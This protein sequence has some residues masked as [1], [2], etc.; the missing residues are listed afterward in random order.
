MNAESKVL[1]VVCAV[2][3]SIV[4][5]LS[6]ALLARPAAVAAPDPTPH[7]AAVCRCACDYCQHC[8]YKTG[9]LP[10]G[11]VIKD[12]LLDAKP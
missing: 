5:G 12:S 6:A 3:L 2:L 9:T 8:R 1:A 11:K 10:S 4:T 7:V